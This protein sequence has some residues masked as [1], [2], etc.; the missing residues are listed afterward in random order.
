MH[1]RGREWI[2]LPDSTDDLLMLRPVGGLD[3]EVTGLLPA[4]EPVQ[5]ATFSFPTRN[6]LG[7]Y[8]AGTLLRDAARIS[9]RAAAGPFRSFGRIAVDPRPYQLVPLIMALRLDPIR[10]LIADDVG[11]GKTVEACLIARELLDRGEIKTLAV[12]CPP[13]LAE[14][15]QKEL[16]S[17][18]HLEAEL[19][20]SSTIQRLERDLPIGVSVFDRHP[21]V[22]VSTDFIKG[23]GRRDDFALKCPEFVIVDEAHGCTP[24]GGRGAGRQLR[25][26]LI[27]QITQSPERHVVL[28]TAT[29][30][31]GNEQAFR[32]LLG[33][34]D[35]EFENLPSEIELD[36]RESLRKKL[37]LHLVQRRRADIRRFLDTDTSFPT[38]LDKE[39]TY[40]FSPEYRKLF[41]DVIQFAREFVTTGDQQRR[42][43][44]VRYWSALALLRCF[45]SSPAAAV[46]TLRNRADV[47]EGQTVEEVNQIGRERV[48]DESEDDKPVV[49]DFTPGA[50]PEGTEDEPNRRQ[51]LAFARRAEEMAGKSDQ[52]LIE[53]TRHI[54]AL[55]AAGSQPIV[56]CRFIDTAD[57]VARHL[58]EALAKN[59]A[60][61]S[62][63]GTLPPSEREA[64]IAVLASSPQH[65]LVC[66][67]CLSEGIN[68]QRE[69]DAVVHYDLCWNP[70]R[71]EQREGRVDRFGQ[72][73]PEVRV[74]TFYGRDNPID[75]VILDVLLRKHKSIKSDLG[76]SVAVP[77]SSEEV[78]EA[79]FE[80]ALFREMAGSSNDQLTFDFKS[81]TQTRKEALHREW[82]NARDKEKASRSRYAQNALKPELVAAEMNAVRQALGSPA[83]V[84]LFFRQAMAIANVPIKPAPMRAI[85]VCV[86]EKETP[87]ALR[88]ALQQETKFAGRFDLP[89]Q[90]GE[91]YLGRT[92]PAVE[93]LAGWV[94]DQAL[95]PA[96]RDAAPVA[97]RCGI[98]RTRR[99]DVRT[100]LVV[101]RFRY[102]LKPRVS[103]DLT[104]LCEEIVP[105]AFHG[106]AQSPQWIEG[107]QA[108]ALLSARP[109][110]NINSSL[111]D[112][113][114]PLLL[115]GLPDFQ[116]AL[117][118]IASHR[119][120]LQLK[121]HDRVRE[122]SRA[123][124]KV[125][126]EPV[127]PVDIL[128]AYLLLPILQ[129]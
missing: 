94:L 44:R 26:E 123:K 59:I 1:A 128:G 122:A 107:E 3:E 42:A 129:G 57:Y 106:S 63:T 36:T 74:L 28:V 88:Q 75:G 71:H 35:S 109:D 125:Q 8:Q 91:I 37:A 10:L 69:F 118:Q 87:R 76:V 15:W 126:I 110:A 38:R 4:V 86:H 12:L 85:E 50:S 17:K 98:V 120:V 111:V 18:F 65:V 34:L 9:T 79:L 92:S 99:V 66:T 64:R 33:L 104:L 60:V 72:K 56:F 21:F 68:L 83:D 58:R 90:D 20:L 48:M 13:H 11:I 82:E 115:G 103:E 124:A 55:L 80:G 23:K 112:Q 2:V 16:A 54:K 67:D 119:A 5:S 116:I 6:D 113:Q 95:D 77:G 101:V 127:L 96:A 117:G 25:Y 32:S 84:E 100:T 22:I 7:D 39:E 70:T 29:P 73:T 105:L 14:Q 45:S 43:Q 93:G 49:P 27:R 108:E 53:A 121:A 102:H 51:L 41:L 78:A 46:A 81:A 62:V 97:A 30:H 114:L 47:E 31:S 24:A 40:A 52:K 19:I 61:D 89:L